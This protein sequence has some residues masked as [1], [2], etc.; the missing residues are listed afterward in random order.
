M[1]S[2]TQEEFWGCVLTKDKKE[3]TWDPQT[4]SEADVEHKLQLSTA[5]LGFKAKENERNL[6]EVTTE[7][8]NGKD[9]TC[10]IVVLRVGGKECVHIDLGFTNKTKFILKEGSGPLALSGVHL[11]ALPLDFEDEEDESEDDEVPKLVQSKETKTESKAE[12]KKPVAADG[13]KNAVKDAKEETKVAETKAIKR[14]AQDKSSNDAKKKKVEPVVA[15]DNE[16]E[17]SD[18]EMPSLLDNEAEEED[19]EDSDDGD[20]EPEDGDDVDS[21]E[22]EEEEDEEEDDEEEEDEEESEEESPVK[23]NK[24]TPQKQQN[25]KPAQTENKTPS[26][27]KVSDKKTPGKKDAAKT[28]QGKKEN[29]TQK[30]P[31]S[32][33]EA[34]TPQAKKTPD[35]IKQMLLKSPNVPKTFDKFVNFMKNNMKVVDQTT[36]KEF[37]DY[38]QKNKK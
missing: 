20:D 6:V 17:S 29:N 27:Q 15:A 9:I 24:K 16:E 33:K 14:P 18:E 3:F 12:T 37:W 22:D 5:C 7:D 28:P 38:V 31:Q 30:T 10:P 23:I 13:D 11:Q 26:N 8:N 32:K 36:Q 25:G 21:D 4:D 19:D 34:K 35:E 1:A 2:D